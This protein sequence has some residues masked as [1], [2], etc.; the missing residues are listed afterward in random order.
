MK[1]ILDEFIALSSR[2]IKVRQIP[3][4]MRPL[5]DSVQIGD[6]SKLRSLG[7]NPEIPLKRTLADILD[8]WRLED[9]KA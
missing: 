1:D 4:K 6:N 8:Y 3:E 2:Q 5:N 9:K 7:W